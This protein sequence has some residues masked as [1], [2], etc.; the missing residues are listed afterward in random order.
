MVFNRLAATVFLAMAAS[1]ANADGPHA[2]RDI[3]DAL[4]AGQY[5]DVELDGSIVAVLGQ[6]RFL[7]DIM[8]SDIKRSGMPV[9]QAV[10][11]RV[12]QHK[13]SAR[14]I[15]RVQAQIRKTYFANQDE[16]IP[17]DN[18]INL[19]TEDGTPVELNTWAGRAVLP[20]DVRV[21]DR[22]NVHGRKLQVERK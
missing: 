9:D 4:K 8:S 5:L 16:T 11:I 12:G 6:G 13:L 1:V 2:Y 15:S 17:A 21:G 7:L 18:E 3:K 10:S 20:L 19:L 22:V 14:I